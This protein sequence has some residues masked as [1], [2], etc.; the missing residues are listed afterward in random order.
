[1]LKE[2]QKYI[3]QNLSFL[4]DK[5]L[6]IAISGGIDSVVLA[7]LLHKLNYKIALAHC[8]FQLRGNESNLDEEFVKNIAKK[9]NIEIFTTKFNTKQYAENQ[10]LSIQLSARE[11]RYKWFEKLLEEQQF[12][13]LLTAHHADDNLETFL[14]NLSRGT[15]LDGLTGIPQ[16]NGKIVRP[17]LKF[18]RE[19]IE[20]YAVENQILWRE[21]QSNSETKYLR[22]KIRHKIVPNLKELNSKFLENFSKTINY[23]QDNQ[24]IVN[25]KT[26]DVL[27]EISQ[28]KGNITQINIEKLLK[29]SNPKAYLYQILKNY[30]ITQWND[31]FDLLSA[32]SGKKIVTNS[33]I[34]LKDRDFLLVSEN[35][36]NKQL[37]IF[38]FNETDVEI[39]KPIHLKLVNSEVELSKKCIQIDKKL[40]KFPLILRKRR[41]GDVFYPT[42]MN[43]KKKLSKYFKDEK[44]SQF[45]KENVWLLCSEDDIIWVIGMRQDRRFLPKNDEN[46]LKIAVN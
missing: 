19:E 7:Y 40:V 5:K 20:K 38:Y 18:S 9:I 16:K 32:Q 44:L 43:G 8:N 29:L 25:D 14:I 24:Q 26:S 46:V 33:H 34:L 28:K 35:V 36:K 11:L 10:K 23:L 4:L 21:D 45:D 2:F 41:Q 27:F 12:D 30:N 37:S 39:T 42:K 15:G 31:I 3:E 22:N 17:L 6:L 13:Y 1:M